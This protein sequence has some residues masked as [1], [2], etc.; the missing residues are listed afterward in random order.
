MN[1]YGWVFKLYVRLCVWQLSGKN[2]LFFAFDRSV[3]NAQ[4]FFLP[5][6]SLQWYQQKNTAYRIQLSACLKS[7]KGSQLYNRFLAR[8]LLHFS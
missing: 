7:F 2:I 4:L 1:V 6:I 5:N 3:N 8:S